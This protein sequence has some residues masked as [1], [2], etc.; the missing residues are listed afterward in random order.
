MKRYTSIGIVFS[1]V[2]LICL[3][4]L[5]ALHAKHDIEKKDQAWALKMIKCLVSINIVSFFTFA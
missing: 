1:A 3:G 2:G 4:F 5:S